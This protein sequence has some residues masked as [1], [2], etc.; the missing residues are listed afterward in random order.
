MFFSS[1]HRRLDRIERLLEEH[2][3]ATNGHPQHTWRGIPVIWWVIV[4]LVIGI[5]GSDFAVDLISAFAS[6]PAP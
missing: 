3:K 4:L 5:T 2:A 6:S 1:I